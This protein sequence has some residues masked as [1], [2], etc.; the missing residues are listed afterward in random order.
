MWRKQASRLNLR[1]SCVRIVGAWLCGVALCIAE[2]S[3][4][5]QTQRLNEIPQPGQTL[6]Q[7]SET[8]LADPVT[9]KFG[10]VLSVER[11]GKLVRFTATREGVVTRSQWYQGIQAKSKVVFGTTDGKFHEVDSRVVVKLNDPERLEA[12]AEEIRAIRAKRYPGLGYSVLWLGSGQDP[13][14][15]VKQLQS[16]QRVKH[17]VLQFKRPLMIP[18]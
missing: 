16:D 17:A 14:E 15:T 2:I 1:V 10:T 11:R 13:I 12:I 6:L 9:T 7:I 8:A 4:F 5:A 18:L 3:Y